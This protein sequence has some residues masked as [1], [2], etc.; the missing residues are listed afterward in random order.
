[1]GEAAEWIRKPRNLAIVI[2]VIIVI[3]ALLWIFIR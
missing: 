2:V 3:L 1:V